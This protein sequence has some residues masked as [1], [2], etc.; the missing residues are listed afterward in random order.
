MDNISKIQ[1]KNQ[2]NQTARAEIIN[3]TIGLLLL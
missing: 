2:L 1:L 3:I